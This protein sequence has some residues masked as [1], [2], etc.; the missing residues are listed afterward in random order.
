MSGLDF[1]YFKGPESEM[2]GLLPGLRQCSLCGSSGRCFDLERAMSPERLGPRGCVDCL[3]SGRFGFFHVTDAG[4]LTDDGLTWFGD[5]PRGPARVFISSAAGLAEEV[6]VP[7]PLVVPTPTPAAVEELRRTPNFPTCNEVPW[8]VH[9][10]DFMI[11]LGPW[12]PA[13]VAAAADRAGLAPDAFYAAMVEPD[14]RDLWPPAGTEWGMHFPVFTC[15]GCMQY[16][17]IVDLD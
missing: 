7:R 10:G 4:Y 5:P 13:D 16:R 17:G 9:C 14:F 2:R 12:Q 11:Y 1:R 8:P 3:R 15:T 6:Q